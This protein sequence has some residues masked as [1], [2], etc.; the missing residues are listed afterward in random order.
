MTFSTAE[1]RA[2]KA[3]P[4]LSHM[5]RGSS[6]TTTSQKTSELLTPPQ[7]SQQLTA[8]LREQAL[9]PSPAHL[10]QLLQVKVRRITVPCAFLS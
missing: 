9:S 2:R 1:P 4:N 3:K 8:E 6:L 7:H 10:A 5:A